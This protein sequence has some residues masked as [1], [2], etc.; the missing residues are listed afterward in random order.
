M[1]N[2]S[3]FAKIKVRQLVLWEILALAVYVIVMLFA[4]GMDGGDDGL[5]EQGNILF[6]YLVPVVFVYGHLR[7]Q[8]ISFGRFLGKGVVFP[9]FRQDFVSF[10]VTL[11]ASISSIYLIFYPLSFIAP[12]FVRFWLLDD[13]LFYTSTQQTD[14]LVLCNVLEIILLVVIAP[15][16]EEIIFRGMILHRWAHKW[17]QGRAAVFSALLFCIFHA[18]WVGAFLFSLLM[19]VIYLRTGSLYA[20]IF[21]HMVNNAIA[22]V[23]AGLEYLTTGTL[24]EMT[25]WEFQRDLWHGLAATVIFLFGW[26]YL[27]RNRLRG[28]G[29][30]SLPAV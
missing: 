22:L 19:T 16:V 14:H 6:M 25:I 23:F 27:Y 24:A 1:N 29:E 21:F 4:F 18:D 7:R 15:A 3:P 26:P 9:G 5:I 8:N 12:G 17:G 20:C 13:M 11:A 28:L 2:N 10:C 30:M